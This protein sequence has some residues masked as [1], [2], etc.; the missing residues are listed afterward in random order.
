M[1]TE[2]TKDAL[3][4]VGAA[5]FAIGLGAPLITVLIGMAIGFVNTSWSAKIFNTLEENE[6]ILIPTCAGLVF[7]GLVIS[8]L[9]SKLEIT[10]PKKLAKRIADYANPVLES[11]GKVSIR[12]IAEHLGADPS[13]VESCAAGM[14]PRGYFEDVKLKEGWLVKAAPL[15]C[16]YCGEEV[17]ETAKKCPNCGAMIKK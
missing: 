9:A 1:V 3:M 17:P 6:D 16:A 15:K 2:R 4:K 8:I 11:K 7:L 13:D 10:F 12:E 5:F 14:I